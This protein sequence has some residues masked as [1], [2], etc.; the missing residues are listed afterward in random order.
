MAQRVNSYLVKW[1]STITGEYD[2]WEVVQATSPEKAR[3]I[4]S[5]GES[6][7]FLEIYIA[8]VEAL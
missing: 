1:F 7:E 5:Q 3:H 8:E 4:V 2:F 6:E